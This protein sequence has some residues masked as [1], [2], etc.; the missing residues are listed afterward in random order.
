MEMDKTSH[1]W[2]S[3]TPPSPPF[4]TPTPAHTPPHPPLLPPDVIRENGLKPGHK[5]EEI[6][7]ADIYF[8]PFV[9]ATEFK[10]SPEVRA[11]ALDAIQKMIS[12]YTPAHL[13]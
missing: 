12:A 10:S 2:D 6:G 8:R 11:M 1:P 5:V 13:C 4:L 3:L 9:M 7:G